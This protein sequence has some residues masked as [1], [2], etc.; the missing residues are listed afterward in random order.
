VV[1]Q[2][3]RGLAAGA[4][5]PVALDRR[6]RVLRAVRNGI[7]ERALPRRL[8]PHLSTKDRQFVFTEQSAGHPR[9][10]AGL[11]NLHTP[12]LS[13]TRISE[14]APG[15]QQMTSGR[16][17]KCPPPTSTP[18]WSKMT[19]DRGTRLEMLDDRL[20]VEVVKIRCASGAERIVFV[21]G[22]FNIIHPGHLRL[23]NFARTCADRL[24]V[25]LFGDGEPGVALPAEVRREALESLA[26]VSA[27]VVL[28]KS[29]LG[30]FIAAL[31]PYAVVKGKEHAGLHNLEREVV[32]SYG[33]HLI[34]SAGEGRFST[35]DLLRREMESPSEVHVRHAPSF[36]QAHGTSTGR[37]SELVEGFS[38]RRVLVLGDLIIDEYI[39][40]DPLGM[41]QEDPSIVVTPVESRIFMGGAGIVA[42][43]MAG[44]GAKAAFITITGDDETAARSTGALA[45][46]G[47]SALLV[48][49]PS[50]PT[51]L[52]QRFRAANKT[53]LRVSHLRAH[54]A[55][56][57][58]VTTVLQRV[59]DLLP[60]TDLVVFSDFN[61]GCLP[62]PLVD[63]IAQRC[64]DAAIPYVADSQASSQMGDV[65]R[66]VGA[67]MLSATE[68]EV[69]LAVNDF[70][71]GLQN[72]ANRLLETSKAGMLM[73]KLG[74]EGMLVL[75]PGAE[76]LTASLPAMNRNPVDVA[77]AG[78]ALLA[79][80]A[81]A[82]AG[83]GTASECAY[84]G[85]VAAALQVSR[86]GNVPLDRTALLGALKDGQST[87]GVPSA[88]TELD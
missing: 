65:S 35:A 66:Y 27:V 53:L 1:Q 25:G 88:L 61:Y 64:R 56:E 30:A 22:N 51:I 39:T 10:V 6:P 54:D 74:A 83:G 38:A 86:L 44:L 75:T 36:L 48:R 40:C 23:L 15:I 7:D 69:R 11:Q 78:D 18:S 5:S 26:A 32:R 41:S 50:R 60:Q 87:L 2:A 84:L 37:L 17:I 59:D 24:V 68:R 58:F 47:V 28:T 81:L 20:E 82:L 43:H 70:K 49:D 29:E 13:S 57:E 19:P 31:K 42:G 72:V 73:V 16:N 77:G 34:F 14:A 55:G 62:Q 9:L 76:F 79:A 8:A 52:K 80:A 3:C 46:L 45:G 85:S 63:V 67:A 21:S 71:S 12:R 33:G 4:D